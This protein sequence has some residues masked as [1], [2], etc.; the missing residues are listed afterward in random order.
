[1]DG[2]PDSSPGVD[3]THPSREV[4]A[5]VTISTD[6]WR[7]TCGLVPGVGGVRTTMRATRITTG[8][9]QAVKSAILPLLPGVVKGDTCP[10]YTLS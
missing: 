8:T 2:G 7:A 9:S 4:V 5:F 6:A 10:A 3:P 1:M